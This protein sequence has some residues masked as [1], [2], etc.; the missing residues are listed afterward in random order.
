MQ[1]GG[2]VPHVHEPIQSRTRRHW[3]GSKLFLKALA[4][5][6]LADVPI[7]SAVLLRVIILVK[8]R[9]ER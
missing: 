5:R 7:G 1:P 8:A 4:A 9:A 3:R 2:N 6:L